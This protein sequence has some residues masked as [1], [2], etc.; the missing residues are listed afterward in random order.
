MDQAGILPEDRVALLELTDRQR[1]VG[2]FEKLE[3]FSQIAGQD[4]HETL[5]RAYA[6]ELGH[7]LVA[8]QG[9]DDITQ[10]FIDQVSRERFD[11]MRDRVEYFWDMKFRDDT[12]F[13]DE[14]IDFYMDSVFFR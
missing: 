12:H 6:R 8:N 14:L 5:L 1:I 10:R 4:F 2:D 11:Q 13:M 7:M 9:L 3:L